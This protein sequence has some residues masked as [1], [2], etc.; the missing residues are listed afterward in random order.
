MPPC[1][2]Q[3]IHILA[4]LRIPDLLADGPMTAEQLATPAGEL[5]LLSLLPIPSTCRAKL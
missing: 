4:A 5:L 3:V 2:V 1:T